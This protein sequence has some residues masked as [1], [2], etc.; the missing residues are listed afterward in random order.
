MEAA[1]NEDLKAVA[2]RTC[3]EGSVLTF[4]REGF[5]AVAYGGV[6]GGFFMVSEA[7]CLVL[8]IVEL[9]CSFVGSLKLPTASGGGPFGKRLHSG[10]VGFDVA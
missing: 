6:V 4:W 9:F 5:L 7:C 8:G 10:V 3:A 1:V 2:G